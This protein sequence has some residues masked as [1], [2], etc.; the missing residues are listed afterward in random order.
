[1]KPV[2][3]VVV[4][5]L[6]STMRAMVAKEL[7]ENYGMRQEEAAKRLGLTQAAIS[8]YLSGRR[9]R[10][11]RKYISAFK[12]MV[13]VKS[14]VKKIAKMIAD[15]DNGIQETVTVVCMTCVSLRLGQ[16]LCKLHKDI[17]PCMAQE[18]DVCKRLLSQGCSQEGSSTYTASPPDSSASL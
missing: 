2:C 13:S 5:Y 18:C 17:I 15:G 8:Y 7:Y 6:L 11:A 4:K 14:A 12:E 3:E 16:E 1:M 10:V 9:G